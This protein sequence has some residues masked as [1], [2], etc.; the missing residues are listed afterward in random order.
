MTIRETWETSVNYWGVPV[1][2]CMLAIIVCSIVLISCT[3]YGITLIKEKEDKIKNMDCK[4]LQSYYIQKT[5]IYQWSDVENYQ[6][7][8]KDQYV[9]RCLT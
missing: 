5:S 4:T 9:G 8:I 6:Q 3:V 1:V 7:M 2:F